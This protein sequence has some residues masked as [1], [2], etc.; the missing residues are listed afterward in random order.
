MLTIREGRS[1]FLTEIST[2]TSAWSQTLLAKTST[3]TMAIA[4]KPSEKWRLGCETSPAPGQCQVELKWPKSLARFSVSFRSFGTAGAPPERDD[5]RR[6]HI[7]RLGVPQRDLKLN[8]P[9][10]LTAAKRGFSPI[11]PPTNAWCTGSRAEVAA[12]DGFQAGLY[13][14]EQRSHP[15]RT[16]APALSAPTPPINRYRHRGANPSRDCRPACHM[17]CGPPSCDG[18][19]GE[20]PT[21]LKSRS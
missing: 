11:T 18:K 2:V 4:L 9:N 10:V 12:A 15:V 20:D 8:Y 16:S 21:E 13:M 7:D 17:R 14:C 1:S 5:V 6:L 19:A 3:P